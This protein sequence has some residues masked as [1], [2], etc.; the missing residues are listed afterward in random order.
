ML[1][2]SLS[3]FSLDSISGSLVRS[4]LSRKK[5]L[6]AFSPRLPSGLILLFASYRSCPSSTRSTHPKR[7]KLSSFSRSLNLFGG[8][9]KPPRKFCAQFP[10]ARFSSP[11]FPSCFL[12]ASLNFSL[13]GERWGQ[14]GTMKAGGLIISTPKLTS[15]PTPAPSRSI[16]PQ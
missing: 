13:S 1:S 4:R 16:L 2:W 6:G 7:V 15:Y 12:P 3:L 9:P 10:R 8:L 14:G 11:T 5:W